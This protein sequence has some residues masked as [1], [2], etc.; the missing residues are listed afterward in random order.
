MTP[1]DELSERQRELK[2]QNPLTTVIKY[3]Q[4]PPTTGPFLTNHGRKRAGSIQIL[5]D[6]PDGPYSRPPYPYSTLIRY[7]IEASPDKKLTLNELYLAI[8]KRFPWFGQNGAGWK[9]RFRS[10]YAPCFRPDLVVQNSIRHNLSLNKSFIKVPRPLTEP[11]KGSYW[12]VDHSAREPTEADEELASLRVE[13]GSHTREF[14]THVAGSSDPSVSKRKQKRK[15]AIPS[16]FMTDN[17]GDNLTS[18]DLSRWAAARA[19]AVQNAHAQ[20]Q[21]HGH[22]QLVTKASSEAPKHAQSHYW[23]NFGQ[24]SQNGG[25]P[26]YSPP[27]PEATFDSILNG[28]LASAAAPLIDDRP[29]PTA[30][31]TI[32]NHTTSGLG[33]FGPPPLGALGA[34]IPH[35]YF[36][37][38]QYGQHPRNH[39][40]TAYTSSLGDALSMPGMTATPLGEVTQH[41]GR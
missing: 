16:S 30:P 37:F 34:S 3:R 1:T 28:S 19:E 41:G 15:K 36:Q 32:Y 29:D 11:G 9:V 23:S 18:Y 21:G 13:S 40:T 20:G 7:A 33:T 14:I 2:L 25:R 6:G 8:E 35:G 31:R 38:A 10:R 39:P 17:I 4:L 26:V 22:T 24:E 27:G 12:M 5:A